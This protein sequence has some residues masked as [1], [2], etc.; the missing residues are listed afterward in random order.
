MFLGVEAAVNTSAPE[1]GK[2][3]LQ[4]DN[5]VVI[6]YRAAYASDF[7]ENSVIIGSQAAFS[8]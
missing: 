4:M 6:G 5:A 7:L 3:L 1:S 2:E 8:G